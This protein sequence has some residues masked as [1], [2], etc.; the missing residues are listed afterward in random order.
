RNASTLDFG[1]HAISLLRGFASDTFA[2][3]R[4]ALL[5]ADYRWPIARPQRGYGTWPFLVHTVHAAVF[6]DVGHAWTRTF[7]AADVKSSAGAELSMDA[8]AGYSFPFTATVGAAWRLDG[9][10]AIPTGVA[11][12]VRIGRAF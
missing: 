3:T 1:S 12:Y 2:G 8:V 10:G 9:S 11:A 4:V 6:T 5:N 7:S